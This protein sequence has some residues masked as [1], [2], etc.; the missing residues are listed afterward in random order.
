MSRHPWYD[1]A[2][3]KALRLHTLEAAGFACAMCGRVHDGPSRLVA[4]HVVPHRGD[5]RAFWTG[6]LQALCDHPCHGRHKQRA[7]VRGFDD[8]VDP[9]T[10]W[11]TDA[12]HPA[13][14]PRRGAT[15]GGSIRGGGSIFGGKG[16]T[17]ARGSSLPNSGKVLQG[18]RHGRP[19]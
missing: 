15:G 7:E 11:P 18:D 12:R 3:W 6:E 19:R 16:L 4:D 14:A 8:A 9:A 17:T 2:R 10:G 5:E 1:T 13:N